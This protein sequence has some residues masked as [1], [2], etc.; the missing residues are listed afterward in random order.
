MVKFF[1]KNI[2]HAGLPPGT[3]QYVGEKKVDE[4]RMGV[5]DYDQDTVTTFTPATAEDCF[6][7]R[8]SPKVSWINIDGLHDTELLKKIGDHYRIHSLVLEDIVN[9]HQRPKMED[10]DDYLFIVMRMLDYDG[11]THVVTSEQLSLILGPNYVLTFQEREGDVFDPVRK[12]LQK[13]A[14]LR[15]GS[16]D[17]LAYAL[18]DAVV[19]RYFVIL[20]AFGESIEDLEGELVD[21][22]SGKLLEKTHAL[23]RELIVLRKSVW[24]LREV[25]R[26]LE[27]SESRLIEKGTKIFLRDLYDHTIQV[28][29]GVES[30]RDMTSGL[31]DLYLSSV[32]NKMNEVMKVLT[33]I[34]TIFIPLS[35]MAGIYGM[36]FEFMPELKWKWSYPFF[37][38]AVGAV[39]VSMLVYFKRKG[40]I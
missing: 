24:P 16:V 39:A 26:S 40:W 6:P 25:V 33:I 7:Y 19:D 38:G 13:I 36:N 20:E 28:I 2:K 17:Y 23:K 37:W 27:D 4:V 12:R 31:Q 21:N 15:K 34:A 14:R 1:R 29:D 3:V 10:H 9:T 5:W 32:S 8:D 18:L 30:Y 35:F 11:E 22:P